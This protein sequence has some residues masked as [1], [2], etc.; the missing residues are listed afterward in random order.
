ML[1]YRQIGQNI[2]AARK[3][4]GFS[5]EQLAEK[6]WIS[7]THMS[8]IETGQTKLSL[9]VLVDLANALQVSPAKLLSQTT[10]HSSSSTLSE[11]N[12]ILAT[13]SPEQLRIIERIIKAVQT[14]LAEQT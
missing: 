5:Q 2:R 13:C 9:P 11:I 6:V 10:E 4:C 1:N 14:A 7:V 3:I 12:E 8:H